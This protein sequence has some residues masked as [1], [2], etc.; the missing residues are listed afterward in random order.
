[1]K[2]ATNESISTYV[3]PK[4]ESFLSKVLKLTM[5]A[6][7]VKNALE[8]N[9]K[10]G[11]IK[12]EA[13]PVSKTLAKLCV[14][15]EE[16]IGGRNVW[17][18]APK[19]K[20]SDKLIFFFH[21]GGYV[22]NVYPQHW[23]LIAKLIEKTGATF[24]VHDYHLVPQHTHEEAFAHTAEVYDWIIKKF[25][26]KVISFMGDSAGGGL[27]LAFAQKLKKEN[28]TLPTQLILSAPWL[29]ATLT[30]PDIAAIDK[31]DTMLGVKGLQ[32]AAKAYAK[33]LPLNDFH[34]SPINGDFKNLPKI[35]LFIG[36]HDIFWADAKKL[37]AFLTEEN[38]AHNYFEY[39]KMFH[40]W[41]IIVNLPESKKVIEQMTTLINH[42]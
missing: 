42:E 22:F 4:N 16:I 8:K 18:L 27:A 24:V 14:V 41:C 40:N 3:H 29:D 28:K 2:T 21:G 10:T 31:N 23:D 25:S 30:N 7:G 36:T 12:N 11:K 5:R 19:D 13:A 9:L 32:M 33:N 1:M 38:I 34:I 37:S 17:T 35:S 26:N 15:K 20:K 6:A 39:P